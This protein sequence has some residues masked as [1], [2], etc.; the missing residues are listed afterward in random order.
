MSLFVSGEQIFINLIYY[1]H[2]EITGDP[3]NLIGPQKCDLFMNRTILG[4]KLHLLFQPMRIN[5]KIKQPI[6][7][8]ENCFCLCYARLSF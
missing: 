8:N 7:L 1:I 5:T 6:K 2:Y 3:C 4:S